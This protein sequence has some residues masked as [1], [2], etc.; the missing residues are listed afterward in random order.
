MEDKETASNYI[1][2]ARGLAMKRASLGLNV[3]PRE[4]VYYTVRGINNQYKNICEILKTQREKFLEEIHEI[5]KEHEKES[6]RRGNHLRE[7]AYAIQK[8]NDKKCYIYKSD[9]IAKV[10]WNRKNYK[11]DHHKA[12]NNNN[13]RDGK[14]NSDTS[15]GNAERKKSANSIE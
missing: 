12:T 7:S 4:L 13:R 3:T 5:L 14:K 2:C 10:C 6:Q 1:A 11:E 9:H 8:K 15:R